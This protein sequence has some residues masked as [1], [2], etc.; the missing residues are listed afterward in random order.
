MELF[1][2][3]KN[4]RSFTCSENDFFPEETDFLVEATKFYNITLIDL[5]KNTNRVYSHARRIEGF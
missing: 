1:D 5:A 4:F 2:I 3:C